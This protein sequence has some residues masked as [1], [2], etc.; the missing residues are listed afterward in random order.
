MASKRLALD[1]IISSSKKKRILHCVAIPRNPTFAS[2]SFALPP[3]TTLALPPT[4]SHPAKSL[5]T[6]AESSTSSGVYAWL[7]SLSD[8][9]AVA[10]QRIVNGPKIDRK[11]YLPS[12]IIRRLSACKNPQSS[13]RTGQF[14]VNWLECHISTIAPNKNG[15]KDLGH[16]RAKI[17]IPKRLTTASAVY[18]ELSLAISADK[19]KALNLLAPKGKTKGC[20]QVRIGVHYI[21]YNSARDRLS[22]Q[23]LEQCG[24]GASVSHLCDRVGCCRPEHCEFVTKHGDNSRRQRC[25][26]M[27]LVVDASDNIVKEQP[28]IHA[29]SSSVTMKSLEL[30]C[31]RVCIVPVGIDWPELEALW[32]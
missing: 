21:A 15:S 2:A 17:T 30:C 5:D 27:V 14:Y 8:E 28:C 18:R 4:P 12:P 23:S 24:L 6:P 26:G 31:R 7:N 16:P 29:G 9:E 25:R 13:E 19:I 11:V 1:P 20:D 22:F 10:L 32:A 3:L